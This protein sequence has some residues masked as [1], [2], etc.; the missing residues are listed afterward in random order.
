MQLISFL[1]KDFVKNV[2]TLITGSVFSQI[3]IYAAIL[4]LTRLFSTVPLDGINKE[5]V[6]LPVLNLPP[7][8]IEFRVCRYTCSH[9]AASDGGLD[10]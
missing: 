2:M 10:E 8:D 6:F 4:V 9:R 5:I 7:P 3:I 1:K